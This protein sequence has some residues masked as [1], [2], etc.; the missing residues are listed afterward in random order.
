MLLERQFSPETQNQNRFPVQS[1]REV[2]CL[3]FLF[4]ITDITVSFAKDILAGGGAMTTSKSVIAPSSRSSCCR[5][6]S[7]PA[8]KSPQINCQLVGKAGAER[9]FRGLSDCLVKI[10]RV[11]GIRGLY[12]GFDVS[13]EGITISGAAYFAIYSMT[14]Q[15]ECFQMPRL[16]TSSQADDR[17]VCHRRSAW[18]SGLSDTASPPDDAVE[19]RRN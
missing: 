10:Y 11:D 9:E 15:T 3:P 19:A 13:V 17:T 12:Q 6:C 4:N 5:R 18:T 7:M 8:S 14:Q 16:L 2:A 1:H